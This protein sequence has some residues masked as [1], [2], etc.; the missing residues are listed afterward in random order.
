MSFKE[1]LSEALVK[2]VGFYNNGDSPDEAIVKSAQE[3]NFN[4]DQTDRL[5]EK[6][7]TAR[8][9]NYFERN[10]EDRTQNF[11][12]ASKEKVASIIRGEGVEKKASSVPDGWHDYSCYDGA[13]SDYFS[14]GEEKTAEESVSESPTA[15]YS[16][17]TLCGIV[18][19]RAELM[20]QH[21]RK[22][23]DSASMI[24]DVVTTELSK[25]AAA[26]GSGYDPDERVAVFKAACAGNPLLGSMEG[27]LPEWMRKKAASHEK[28]VMRMN[29]VDLGDMQKLAEELGYLAEAV[30]N[31]ESYEKKAEKV[32]SERRSVLEKLALATGGPW[33][34][35]NAGGGGGGGGN[36]RSQRYQDA[37]DFLN[38]GTAN[39]RNVD[40]SAD[41]L[42]S[43]SN[44][45]SSVINDLT[46]RGIS[47]YMDDGLLGSKEDIAKAVFKKKKKDTT[48]ADHI[49]NLRRSSILQDLYDNDP[50]LSEANPKELMNAY[51][52]IVQTSPEVSLN[53]EVVRAILRQSVNSMAVSPFDAKQWA[54]L[55]NVNLKNKVLR[56]DKGDSG[57][58][59]EKASKE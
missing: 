48:I 33:H 30:S 20:K 29:V 21:A 31:A 16:Y 6:F 54:D 34:G 53:K 46:P 32:E 24:R 59:K 58:K 25:I 40:P 51:S 4:L 42:D 57:S 47:E 15:G 49:N 22:L 45:I 35:P 23:R 56:S 39:L 52:T 8:T 3:M 12:I 14:A 1:D 38:L 10:P 41:A 17:D 26:V 9:I 43:V 50:I 18:T 13:E 37:S 5:V 44:S 19:K 7:N 27:L 2:A 28:R 36:G 55:E 11:P